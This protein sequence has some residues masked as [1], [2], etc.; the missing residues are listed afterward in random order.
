[1]R[2]L[3]IGPDPAAARDLAASCHSLLGQ[4][5]ESVSTATSYAEAEG[6][7][8]ALAYDLVLLTPERLARAL[9]RGETEVARAGEPEQYLAVRR[10]GR[11]DLV[12]VDE[13]LY[14]EGADKYSELVLNDGRRDFYDKTLSW[15]EAALPSNFLRIHKSYLVPIPSITRL[16]VL[17]GSRY[18]AEL[19]NGVRL[20]VGRT[21][22]RR[23]RQRFL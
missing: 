17:G 14:V 12:A 22:Y 20:P 5:L 1:M 7:L 23:I 15:L 18:Q 13:V 8:E 19:K 10:R 6:R 11:I 21:R 9:G 4:R 16:L 3:V 2:I